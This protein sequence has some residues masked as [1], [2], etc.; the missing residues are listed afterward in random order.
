M[1]MTF[2]DFVPVC[3]DVADARMLRNDACMGT[4]ARL[5]DHVFWVWQCLDV[6]QQQTA[7][8]L[9]VCVT[10]MQVID[11]YHTFPWHIYMSGL[12]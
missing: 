2:A 12:S 3:L 9:M 1:L 4:S 10:N 8:G 6:W 7:F 11:T 5:G